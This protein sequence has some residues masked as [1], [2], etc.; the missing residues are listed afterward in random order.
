M[1][2]NKWLLFSFILFLVYL[3]LYCC[4]EKPPIAIWKTSSGQEYSIY[5]IGV[6]YSKEYP[7]MFAITYKSES[8]QDT[9]ISFKE[10][11][12]LYIYIAN[13]FDLGDFTHVG[14]EARDRNDAVLGCASIQCY[15]INKTVEEVMKFKVKPG[16]KA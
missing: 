2:F 9:A 12:D 5:K 14:L 7:K 1:K 15:R 4:G 6:W 8:P 11:H 3:T 10:F 13:N 16:K